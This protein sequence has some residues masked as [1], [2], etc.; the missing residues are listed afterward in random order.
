MTRLERLLHLVNLFKGRDKITLAELITE[1]SV[2][3]RTIYRDLE[4]LSKMNVPIQYDN[5]YF[6]A[7]E[8]SLPTFNFTKEE[9]ELI[10]CSLKCSPLTRLPRFRDSIKDIEQ[11]ILAT[12][13]KT[14]GKSLNNYLQGISDETKVFA[15]DENIIIDRFLKSLEK[16]EP[17]DLL[18]KSGETMPA[19]I[20]KS[21]IIREAGWDLTLYEQGK[22]T[23]HNISLSD[24]A[25]LEPARA[26][27]ELMAKV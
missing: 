26:T 5:G 21:L 10:G 11:K 18:L 8:V 27:R 2:S 13:N 25:R 20:P 16:R 12:A 23:V 17:L 1:C 22:G 14:E 19:L 7:G 15:G 6:L 24:I 9:K 3:K 4:T